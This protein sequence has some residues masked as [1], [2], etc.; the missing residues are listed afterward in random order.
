MALA[1]I[2]PMRITM[3]QPAWLGELAGLV[4]AACVSEVKDRLSG[5]SYRWS[6]PGQLLGHWLRAVAPSLLEVAGGNHGGATGSAFVDVNLLAL[7]ACLDDVESFT[8]DPNGGDN[9][10]LT[11]VGKRAGRDVVVEVY[12]VPFDD[13]GPS[14]VFDVNTGSWRDKPPDAE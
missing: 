6:R 14:T 8:Y 1:A 13:D 10:H 9:P 7:A 2:R 11:L 4:I 12:L 5:F 3:K